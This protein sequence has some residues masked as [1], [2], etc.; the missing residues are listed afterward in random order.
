MTTVTEL[1]YG[2]HLTSSSKSSSKS[3]TSLDDNAAIVRIFESSAMMQPSK[4]EPASS[5]GPTQQGKMKVTPL[6]S[7]LNS[8]SN[9]VRLIKI[10]P[11]KPGENLTCQ[12]SVFHLNACPGF[13]ALSYTWGDMK[14]TAQILVDDHAFHIRRNLSNV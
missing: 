11:A 1:H 6:Y 10:N 9:C 5:V 8:N 13:T 2:K 7:P 3:P 4:A 14:P 12:F